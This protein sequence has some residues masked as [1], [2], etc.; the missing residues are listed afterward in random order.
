MDWCLIHVQAS[1]VCI[2][3]LQ[4]TCTSYIV[5]ADI[6]HPVTIKIFWTIKGCPQTVRRFAQRPPKLLATGVSPHATHWA[7]SS[8]ETEFR[9]SYVFIRDQEEI[10]MEF[11]YT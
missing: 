7:Y 3:K 8:Y 5:A 6:G 10:K 4:S 1:W 2:K 9:L 11:Q